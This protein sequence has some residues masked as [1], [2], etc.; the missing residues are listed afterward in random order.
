MSASSKPLYSWDRRVEFAETDAAGIVHFSSFFVYMEQAEHA[1]FRHC[2]WTI[3][4]QQRD[5][6]RAPLYTWP[7]V[8]CSCDYRAP[9]VFEDILS[10]D[11]FIERLGTK[12]VT[13]RHLIRRGTEVIAE[14]RVTSVCSRVDP[15][16]HQISGV[17]I[18]DHFRQKFQSLIDLSK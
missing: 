8:H 10:I 17:V 5:D 15:I 7:R 1:L 11:V 4:P 3:F 14:G 6:L 13:Y 16:T 9:A 2:G 12:S 18:P